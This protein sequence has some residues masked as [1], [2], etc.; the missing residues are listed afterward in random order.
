MCDFFISICEANGAVGRSLL[1]E[2]VGSQPKD[3]QKDF[4][5]VNSQQR[6]LFFK[7]WKQIYK[8]VY[9]RNTATK[10]YLPADYEVRTKNFN[11]LLRSMHKEKGYKMF[12]VGDE[13][14]VHF[15]ELQNTTLAPKG[16]KKVA[17][18]TSNMEKSMFIAWLS[19]TIIV[20]NDG[21]IVDID[22]DPVVTMFAGVPDAKI[23]K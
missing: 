15:E 21:T 19:C 17:L 14:G 20:N 1:E 22:K 11:S 18:C 13:T 8:V 5:T 10:Q 12:I 6:N 7:R 16:S 2:W 4:M 9:R 3:V 23:V